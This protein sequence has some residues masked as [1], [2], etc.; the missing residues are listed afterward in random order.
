MVQKILV[1]LII[2]AML[3]LS[4]CS[5]GSGDKLLLRLNDQTAKV[6]ALT[7]EC[8][9][10]K[11]EL[12]NRRAEPDRSGQ[13]SVSGDVVLQSVRPVSE[14]VIKA[15]DNV[16]ALYGPFNVL[17]MVKN[18]GDQVIRNL[19]LVGEIHRSS[20]DQVPPKTIIRMAVIPELKP[21]Q[22][23]SAEIRDF[24]VDRPDITQEL[25]VSAVDHGAVNQTKL[26]VAS[27]PESVNQ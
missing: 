25:I 14:Q 6:T 19:R 9:Q 17:V 15:G 5:A 10:L 26:R 22:T 7:K 21:G 2:P 12:A 11:A 27:P 16:G 1:L 4:G 8:D 3:I 20:A 18:T 24:P 23:S 13:E